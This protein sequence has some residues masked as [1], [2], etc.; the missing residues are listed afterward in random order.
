MNSKIVQARSDENRVYTAGKW[1]GGGIIASPTGS[2]ILEAP[3]KTAMAAQVNKSL[4]RWKD[5][6]PGTHPLRN[7]SS[8]K[9][10][11]LLRNL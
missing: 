11:A 1:P 9:T 5:M 10:E 4:T 2:P 8:A 3:N 7:L 6:A